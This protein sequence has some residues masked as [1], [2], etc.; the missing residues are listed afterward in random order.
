MST[1]PPYGPEISI[2]PGRADRTSFSEPSLP[3]M[4]LQWLLDMAANKFSSSLCYLYTE[5]AYYSAGDAWCW[6]MLRM[7]AVEDFAMGTFCRPP[8]SGGSFC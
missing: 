5:T 4:C 8:Y 2:H 7:S 1:I 3:V 6:H